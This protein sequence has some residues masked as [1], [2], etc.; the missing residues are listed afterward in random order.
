METLLTEK[1]LAGRSSGPRFWP[2]S[3]APP[4]LFCDGGLVEA[5][6]QSDAVGSEEGLGKRRLTTCLKLEVTLHVPP[7]PLLL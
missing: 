4:L 2:V 6:G 1:Q 7:S 5:E 3:V